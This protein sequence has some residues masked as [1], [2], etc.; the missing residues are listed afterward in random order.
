[1]SYYHKPFISIVLMLLFLGSINATSAETIYVKPG[2]DG[3][4]TSWADA[5]GELQDALFA[6]RNDEQIDQI[7]VAAGTYT[8]DTTGV[9]DPNDTFRMINGVAIYGGF[10]GTET[11][12]D[13]RDIQANE[14]IL[15]GDIG[16]IDDPNDNCFHVFYHDAFALLDATAVLDGFTITGGYADPAAEFPDDAGGGM[17]N[18]SSSPTVSNCIFENNTAFI[19]GGMM[20][21]ED[22]NPIVTNCTF[23]SNT[24]DYGGGM[25]NYFSSPTVTDCTFSLNFAWV[26]GGG[27]LNEDSS[28]TVTNCTFTTNVVDFEGFAGGGM[29]NFFGSPTVTD[30]IFIGNA[31]PEGGGMYNEEFSDPTVTNCTFSGNTAIDYGGGMANAFN[32]N[33]TVTNCTFSGNTSDFTGGGMDNYTSSPTITNSIFWGNSATD[34]GDQIYNDPFDS[35]L[36]KPVIG[37]CNIQ[38]GLP[39][40]SI[41]SGGGNIDIDPNFVDTN[42]LDGIPGTEDDDLRLQDDSPCI[43]AGDN[44]AV[45]VDVETDLDGNPRIVGGVVD[46][47]AYENQTDTPFL[48]VTSPI[49]NELWTVGETYDITWDTSNPSENVAIQLFKGDTKLGPLA[50]P[51]A[52]DGTYPW[53]IGAGLADGTDYRIKVIALDDTSVFDFSED[54]TIANP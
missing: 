33:P 3:T 36:S 11:A 51:T 53:T 10:A 24:A 49:L 9:A 44:T 38:G 48:T 5:Y 25:F 18:V 4:G 30:C 28:P 8:P 19:G 16:V 6:A 14:T 13:Q 35:P 40:G 41:G 43:N 21:D 12:L 7:W 15:S 20:S 50:N 37:Y 2:G 1:M 39:A 45:P 31:A 34:E 32:C 52:N 54:F 26:N 42:G 22:S 46:M 29:D 47:G 27:M 17:L 23:S